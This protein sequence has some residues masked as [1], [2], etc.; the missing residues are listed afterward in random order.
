MYVVSGLNEKAAATV[1]LVDIDDVVH[2]NPV[3]SIIDA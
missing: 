2:N 3:R 1:V